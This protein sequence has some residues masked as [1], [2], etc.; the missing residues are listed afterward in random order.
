MF[1]GRKTLPLC[2]EMCVVEPDLKF[3][4]EFSVSGFVASLFDISVLPS[5]ILRS[6]PCSPPHPAHPPLLKLYVSATS[7]IEL[8]SS[9]VLVC[10]VCSIA[11]YLQYCWPLTVS[12][13]LHAHCT[14]MHHFW[15]FML[16]SH[17]L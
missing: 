2:G 12:I 1:L 14:S 9:T 17:Q 4:L 8:Y 16:L 5:F 15:Y 6:H 10:T 7:P 13:K 11:Y 3:P